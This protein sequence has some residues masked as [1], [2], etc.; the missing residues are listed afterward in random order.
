MK[1]ILILGHYIHNKD[2]TGIT[3]MNLF[4]VYPKDNILIAAPL[5]HAKESYKNGYKKVYVLGS[6]EFPS[7][8]IKRISSVNT[9]SGEITKVLQNLPDNELLIDNKP[10]QRR[11]IFKIKILEK[12]RV[13]ISK[14]LKSF[15]IYYFANKFIF[16][17]RFKRWLNLN[18]PDIIYTLL[19]T[20][21]SIAF[22]QQ[23]SA[24]LNIPIKLH[25]MD[26]WPKTIAKERM[27]GNL[28]NSIIDK[29]FRSLLSKA[30]GRIAISE[31]MAVE[32]KKRYQNEWV[33]FH[34]PIDSKVWCTENIVIQDKQNYTILYSGRIGRGI[35]EP[36]L[37]I[38]KAV[39]L[40]VLKGL[41]IRF[42]I[43]TNSKDQSLI[44][45]FHCYNFTE[46]R[47][48]SDYSE[49]PALFSSVD[50]LLIPYCFEGLDYEFVRLSMPTKASEYMAS[51]TPVLIFA[52]DDT[53]LVYHAK[54][55]KW[56]HV[57]DQNDYL[58][59]SAE[60]ERLLTNNELRWYYSNNGQKIAKEQF[61]KEIVSNSFCKYLTT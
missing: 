35:S 46:I 34:N 9:R 31:L 22:A 55:Y 15:F 44:N 1:N 30:T 25:I 29:E 28:M 19:S 49:L 58:L 26:D 11:I 41:K 17:T 14:N 43:Q 48:Y 54:K 12:W 3:L 33:H 42:L 27:F 18:R 37:T 56:A 10:L 61:E 24:Y 2:A 23:I 13:S 16:S 6:R 20:R 57:V 51:G 52:P 36:L 53:A 50:I 45:S 4:S 39:N 47:G 5:N 38:A 8:L 7:L 59:L 21:E 60:I 32:Y 40:L